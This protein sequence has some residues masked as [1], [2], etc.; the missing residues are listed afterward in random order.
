MGATQAA[1]M[2]E[3]GMSL[4]AQLAWHLEYNHFPP[5]TV[6]M[7]PFCEKAIEM[8]VAG[9][10]ETEILVGRDGR[11]WEVPAAQIVEDLHLGTWVD[12]QLQELSLDE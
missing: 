3:S 8:V 12:A 9:E 1:G 10:G 5:I 7:V 11:E 4:D 6:E 2:V